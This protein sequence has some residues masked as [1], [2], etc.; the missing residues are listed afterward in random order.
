MSFNK[1]NEDLF[2][3]I[4]GLKPGSDYN[5]K[6]NLVEDLNFDSLD[7]ISFLFEVQSMF[8]IKIPDEDIDAHKLFKLD[9]LC[10]YI[11]KKI[12]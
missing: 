9:N 11:T 3:L 10:D 7:M 2:G 8:D 6:T 12:K 4:E 1:I 5:E